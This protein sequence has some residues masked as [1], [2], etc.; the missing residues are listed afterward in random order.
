[1]HH[2]CFGSSDSAPCVLCLAWRPCLMSTSTTD[3]VASAHPDRLPRGT[4]ASDGPSCCFGRPLPPWLLRHQWPSTHEIPQLF[5]ILLWNGGHTLL[6]FSLLLTLEG[7]PSNN[8]CAL[9]SQNGS[10]EQLYHFYL[11]YPSSPQDSD[12][13]WGTRPGAHP[14]DRCSDVFIITSPWLC[15]SASLCSVLFSIL[16]RPACE[17]P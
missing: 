15:S 12:T 16:M 17:A 6:L 2:L 1:M 11:Y 13:G 7:S 3:A 14:R 5:R 9:K 4:V 10:P 8:V